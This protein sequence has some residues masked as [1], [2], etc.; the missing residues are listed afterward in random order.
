MILLIVR[1]CSIIK[2]INSINNILIES[3][4]FF[5]DETEIKKNDIFYDFI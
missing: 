1:N 5:L 3:N 4:K 2:Q